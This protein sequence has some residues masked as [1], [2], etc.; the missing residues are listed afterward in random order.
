MPRGPLNEEERRAVADRLARG[1]AAKLAEMTK[2]VQVWECP[3]CG[4]RYEAPLRILGAL[5][6]KDH[7]KKTR[8][9]KLIEGEAIKPKAKTATAPKAPARAVTPATP[10][11]RV[12]KRRP[13]RPSR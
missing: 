5:C 10:G 4:S 2:V 3:T 6:P 11:V 8:N 13:G 9:M 1:R 12:V 7:G